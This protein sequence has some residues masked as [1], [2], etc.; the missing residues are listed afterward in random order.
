MVAILIVLA[1][2]LAVA[3]SPW[4]G[5]DSRALDDGAWSRDALWSHDHATRGAR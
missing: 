5:Q 2:V 1:V 3:V 4:L